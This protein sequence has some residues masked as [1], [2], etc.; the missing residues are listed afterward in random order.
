ME[1]GVNVFLVKFVWVMGLG[2]WVGEV[3]LVEVDCDVGERCEVKEFGEN[4]GCWLCWLGVLLLVWLVG[5]VLYFDVVIVD[6]DEY[7]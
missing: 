3:R 2:D 4:G 6:E 5:R 7:G 1:R